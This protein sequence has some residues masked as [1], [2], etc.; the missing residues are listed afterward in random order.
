M[1]KF[2]EWS[3]QIHSNSL[4]SAL[5]KHWKQLVRIWRHMKYFHVPGAVG[6]CGEEQGAGPRIWRTLWINNQPKEY[7]WSSPVMWWAQRLTGSAHMLSLFLLKVEPLE[8]RRNWL[9]LTRKEVKGTRSVVLRC[10][11]SVIIIYELH[12]IYL[13]GRVWGKN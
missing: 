4:F 10:S 3:E 12:K 7:V 13:P 1:S 8:S 5:E 2:F 6:M 9:P 11:F